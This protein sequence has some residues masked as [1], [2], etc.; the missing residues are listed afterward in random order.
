MQFLSCVRNALVESNTSHDPEDFWY[1]VQMKARDMKVSMIEG[2]SI[3]LLYAC[4]NIQ[5]ESPEMTQVLK[6]M[7]YGFQK[8]KINEEMF[9]LGYAL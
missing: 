8:D 6:T 2:I 1:N 5:P 7:D 4:E 9:I 3:I